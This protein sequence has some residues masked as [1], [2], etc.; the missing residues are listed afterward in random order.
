M[1]RSITCLPK[2]R[3]PRNCSGMKT[4]VLPWWSTAASGFQHPLYGDGSRIAV[5]S[6]HSRTAIRNPIH[7]H[8]LA[9][10]CHGQ[11]MASPRPLLIGTGAGSRQ[12]ITSVRLFLLALLC[13]LHPTRCLRL[14]LHLGH[15]NPCLPFLQ[16]PG[17]AV[18]WMR[19]STETRATA[20]A[21]TWTAN[22]ASLAL[23]RCARFCQSS[24]PA[25]RKSWF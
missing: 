12:S 21:T 13:K 5:N 2:W 19:K 24:I 15:C 17:L 18:L 16:R 14:A 10:N 23:T 6:C 8:N 9:C 7:T 4:G 20:S 25:R 1:P 11:T 3:G 22:F